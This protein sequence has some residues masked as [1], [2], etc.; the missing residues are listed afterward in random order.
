MSLSIWRTLEYFDLDYVVQD[1]QSGGTRE[2]ALN[3]YK[4]E[5][6]SGVEHVNDQ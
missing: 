1:P 3:A 4:V 2:T 5:R 6:L